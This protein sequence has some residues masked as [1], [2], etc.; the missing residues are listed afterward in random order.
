MRS[1]SSWYPERVHAEA[2]RVPYQRIRRRSR[3]VLVAFLLIYV[4]TDEAQ[5]AIAPA[6]H[7]V[8]F[9]SSTPI[10]AVSIS[11]HRTLPNEKK[12]TNA[13]TRTT[14]KTT[15]LEHV[16]SAP[17]AAA[18]FE[19][20]LYPTKM[21]SKPSVPPEMASVN[22]AAYTAHVKPHAVRGSSANAVFLRPLTESKVLSQSNSSSTL[23]AS[24][25]NSSVSTTSTARAADVGKDIVDQQSTVLQDLSHAPK[26]LESRSWSK[27]SSFFAM[28]TWQFI[29]L[30]LGLSLIYLAESAADYL[31]EKQ[32]RLRNRVSTCLLFGANFR[33][34]GITTFA[35]LARLI[36][37]GF[38]HISVLQFLSNLGVLVFSLALFVFCVQLDA[39]AAWFGHWI[40]FIYC[41]SAI[42]KALS[43]HVTRLSSVGLSVGSSGGVL[44]VYAA[45]FSF[46]LLY[47]KSYSFWTSL[48]V[49]FGFHGGYCKIVC[50][51]VT[52]DVFF[53]TYISNPPK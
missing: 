23:S 31:A 45:T 2:R 28:G 12:L 13:T 5:S 26:A 34:L 14:T 46:Y 1:N 44:G 47:L 20:V 15:L 22:S 36:T 21:V 7:D 39:S 32:F 29:G 10:A 8:L 19:T 37:S 50:V 53:L 30:I 27:F 3:Y 51:C 41:V 6:N 49:G 11:Q 25:D 18:T 17:S 16:A 40:F 24:P 38:L 9:G 48:L 52:T 42:T 35:F 33:D 4:L 43:S